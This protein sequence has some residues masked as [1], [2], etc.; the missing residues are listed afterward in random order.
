MLH[1]MMRFEVGRPGDLSECECCVLRMLNE[2]SVDEMRG[3]EKR[4]A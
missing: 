4:S 3:N 2:K 1:M